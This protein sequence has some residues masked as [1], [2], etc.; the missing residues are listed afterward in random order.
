MWT[1]RLSRALIASIILAVSAAAAEPKPEKLDPDTLAMVEAF[2]KRP[3]SELPAQHIDR[4]VAVDPLSLPLRLRA[5][6]EARRLEL[7]TLKSLAAGKKKGTVRM[8][9]KDCAIPDDTR[10]RGGAAIYK[11]AGY[12]EL[13][14]DEVEHLKGRTKC[15][16]PELMCEFSLRIVV[17]TRNKR[18][19]IKYFLHVKDP[20]SAL[21]A[22]YRSQR[23]SRQTNFFGTMA[24]TCTR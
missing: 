17:E 3:L 16:E 19:D 5:K 10:A 12:M 22:E 21:V 6:Y 14:E 15:T 4:F 11:M 20:L 13:F 2:L 8:P 18:K 9:E 24:P 7:F 1:L 23:R